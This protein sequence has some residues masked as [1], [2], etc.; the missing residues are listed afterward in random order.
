MASTVCH[1]F[2]TVTICLHLTVLY[3]D[4][5]MAI[6]ICLRQH[7]FARIATNLISNFPANKASDVANYIVEIE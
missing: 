4:K 3:S 7:T 1:N 6:V 5:T 2:C